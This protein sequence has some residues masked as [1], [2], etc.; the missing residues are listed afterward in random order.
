MIGLCIT[1][2]GMG[3]FYILTG[4]I[5]KKYPNFISVYDALDEYQKQIVPSL[6][7]KVLVVGGI[8][9]MIGSFVAFLFES[10]N[11]IIASMLLPG[12]IMPIYHVWKLK[13]AAKSPKKS[14]DPKKTIN[15][16]NQIK[17]SNE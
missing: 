6:T 7:L 4:F 15:I 3:A 2:V 14:K 1:A 9:T 11:G 10:S 12:L 5:C 8:A 16:Y 13:Y 17:N